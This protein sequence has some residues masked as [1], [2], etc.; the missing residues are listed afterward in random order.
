MLI[1]PKASKAQNR[2]CQVDE[3]AREH[4]QNQLPRLPA[5]KVG[6]AYLGKLVLSNRVPRSWKHALILPVGS[7]RTF[8]DTQMEFGRAAVWSLADHVDAVTINISVLGDHI[9]D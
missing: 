7:S 6:L 2:A 1:C 3:L 4:E 9:A 8:S 5:G